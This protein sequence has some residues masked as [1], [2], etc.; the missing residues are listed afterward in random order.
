MSLEARGL[1]DL[2]YN[3]KSQDYT[4]RFQLCYNKETLSLQHGLLCFDTTFLSLAKIK[5]ST[6]DLPFT[7]DLYGNITVH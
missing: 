4:E 6:S 7:H 2:I 5:K 1:S 3:L